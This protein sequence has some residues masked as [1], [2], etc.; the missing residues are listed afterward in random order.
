MFFV[1][2]G[3]SPQTIPDLS[4][5]GLKYQQLP[6]GARIVSGELYNPSDK[7]VPNAQLQLSLF[8]ADNIV[9]SSMVIVVR[10]IPAGERVSF[11]EPVDVSFD[12]QA[13]RVKSVLV[14]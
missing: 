1:F 7:V 12:I 3:C 5:E 8:D 6:S 10:E 14:L 11:R 4:V 13:A 2:C 9:V